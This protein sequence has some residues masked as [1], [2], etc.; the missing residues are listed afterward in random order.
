MS[1]YRI[2]DLNIEIITNSPSLAATIE[3]YEVHYDEQPNVT[4]SM[5]DD[6]LMELMEENEGVTAD[7]V[8]NA[9]LSTLYCWSLFDFNGF[10][11]RAT[12]VETEDGE[13]ILFAAPFEEGFD[14][15]ILLPQDKVF[16]YDYPAVRMEGEDYYCFDTPFGPHGSRSKVGKKLRLRSIVFVDSKRF[17]SLRRIES[18]EFVPMFMRAVALNIR[19]ERTKHTLFVLE[20]VM[21]RV[22]FYGVRGVTPYD[23]DFILERV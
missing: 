21:H 5:S 12:A 7:I 15:T 2:S 20:R 17:D 16:S 11:I 1:I 8:E 22:S 18:K 19:H 9:F 3:R 10:P 23:V 14:P 4:L 13:C 6:L